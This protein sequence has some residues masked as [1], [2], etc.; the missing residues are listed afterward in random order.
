M[1]NA[2]PSLVVLCMCTLIYTIKWEA[3]N[4]KRPGWKE[5][6]SKWAAS[7]SSGNGNFINHNWGHGA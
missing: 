1:L 4:V 6:K 3:N 7:V 2:R 5:V